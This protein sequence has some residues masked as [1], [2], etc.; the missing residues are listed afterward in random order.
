MLLGKPQISSSLISSARKRS[1]KLSYSSAIKPGGLRSHTY[2]HTER[3]IEEPT[4]LPRGG[5]TN[6]QRNALPRPDDVRRNCSST[7][8]ECPLPEARRAS[9]PDDRRPR[10]QNEALNSRGDG[11]WSQRYWLRPTHLSST[12]LD[13]IVLMVRATDTAEGHRPGSR[14]FGEFRIGLGRT[15]PCPPESGADAVSR[16]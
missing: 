16:C 6:C 4:N 9:G 1:A 10:S 12:W 13:T 3:D 15:S 14:A 11:T 2:I 5:P 7:R 8:E